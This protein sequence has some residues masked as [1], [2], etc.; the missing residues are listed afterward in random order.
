MAS[1]SIKIADV[2]IWTPILWCKILTVPNKLSIAGYNF[3]CNKLSIE[4][5]D[6]WIWTLIHWRRIW[7][8]WD[9]YYKTEYAVTQITARFWFIIVGAKWVQTS[10]F[11]HLPNR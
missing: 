2:W 9:Q 1:L 5:A 7:N 6:V 3:S 10:T 11:F 4:F 8:V